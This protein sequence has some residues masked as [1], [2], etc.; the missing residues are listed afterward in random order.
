M[1][2]REEG[3]QVLYEKIKSSR[4]VLGIKTFRRTPSE[5][6][7]HKDLP[8][9]F[10]TEGPD[11][12]I[13]YNSRDWLG[14]PARR[15]VEIVFELITDDAYD[16]RKFFLDFRR[17]ILTSAKV[18]DNC[19]IRELRA[20]GPSGYRSPHVI[21]MNLILGMSYTDHG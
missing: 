10:M 15:E 20:S 19:V 1:E 5:G 21:G 11:K 16:I 3:L 14:Y 2:K 18:T 9:V 17:T 6:V 4:G 13:K 8:C 7:L 12:I